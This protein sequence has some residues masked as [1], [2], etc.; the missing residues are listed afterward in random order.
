[1][2]TAERYDTRMMV[3]IQRNRLKR[4]TS[5]GVISQGRKCL[6]VEKRLVPFL[7]LL[8]GVFVVVGGNRDVTAVYNLESRKER[9]H[10]EGNIIASI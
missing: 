3:P 7:D 2:V 5:D 4:Q 9:V 1:M 8:D 10:L 6:S